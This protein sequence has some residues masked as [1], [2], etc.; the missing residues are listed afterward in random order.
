M[1]DITT[2]AQI[3]ELEN[4]PSRFDDYIKAKALEISQGNEK[5]AQMQRNIFPVEDDSKSDGWKSAGEYFGALHATN[6][7]IYDPRLKAL[8][9]AEGDQGGFLVPEEFRNT[10]LSI[11]LEQSVIR[12]RATPI[13]MA[14]NTVRIPYIR[15]AS[16]ASTVFGGVRGY[17]DSEAATATES[18][19]TFA[20][21]QLTAK[22]LVGYT[23]VSNE[24]LADSAIA[25]EALL[26]A[27]FGAAIAYFEDD[28]FINGDGAGEPLGILN[29]D[30]L[31]TVAKETGQAATTLT[32]Q[33][34]LKMYSRMLPTSLSRAV[35]IMHP[36]TFPQL[37]QMAMSVGTGGSPVFI[38]NAVGGTPT[39]LFGRQIVFSEKCQTLGTKGDI[40]F[41]DLSYYLIGERQALTAAASPHVKFTTDQ[42]VYRFIK[43]LDG[44]P[45]LDTAITPRNGSNTLSPFVALAARA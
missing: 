14:S 9:E 31:V 40:Y 37:A 15:D 18:E 17:W 38:A 20:Q 43:R 16:H 2:Q 24:L 3:E 23:V 42:T 39:S 29:S 13:P 35:W 10:L 22:K 5:N 7:G 12:P 45:W 41:A 26:Q 30:A 25:L 19:P 8:N 6:R 28:A 27:Q 32:Y 4:D 33:N 11:A 36:D 1:A 44:R 34:V 21:L